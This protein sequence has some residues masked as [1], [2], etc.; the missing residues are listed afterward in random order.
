M[1]VLEIGNI[2]LS[3]PRV[4]AFVGSVVLTAAIYLFL[5]RTMVGKAMT[6]IA[7]DRDAA[8]L[9]GVNVDQIY[10]LSFALNAAILGVAGVFF[11]PSSRC[12]L[13]SVNSLT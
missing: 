7:Q 4:Y 12:F 10:R 3:L 8:R 2:I 11:C 5:S 9:I 1:Q 6:A 13:K